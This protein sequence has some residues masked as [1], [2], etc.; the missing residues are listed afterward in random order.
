MTRFD[1]EVHDRAVRYIAANRFPFPGQTTWKP[2]NVTI[3]NETDKRVGILTSSGMHYPDIVIT[4]EDGAI[5]ETGEVEIDVKPEYAEYWRISSDAS[6]NETDTGVKHFFV[7]VPE[8]W[9]DAAAHLID[10]HEIS[11]SGLRT[12]RVSESGAISVAP[13]VTPGNEEDHR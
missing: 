11:Y 2:D 8:G 3:T 9:E 1:R 7:Y 5:R 4:G 12:Y 6:D 10:E 13:V